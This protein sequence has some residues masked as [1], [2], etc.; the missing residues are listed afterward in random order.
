MRLDL[1]NP[2]KFY[3][4]ALTLIGVF[5]LMSLGRIGTDNAQAWG[6]IGSIVGYG[7][8]NGIAAKNQQP[9]EPVFGAKRRA[10]PGDDAGALELR[11]VLGWLIFV[12]GVALGALVCTWLAA[13][14]VLMLR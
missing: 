13:Q 5:V 3:L 14:L 10:A 4:L 6:L 1:N 9:V 7:V 11:L 2:P 12:V 8:G